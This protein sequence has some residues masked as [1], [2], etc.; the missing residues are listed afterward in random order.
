MNRARTNGFVHSHVSVTGI[1]NREDCTAMVA[2][3]FENVKSWYNTM[4]GLID[5]REQANYWLGLMPGELRELLDGGTWQEVSIGYSGVHVFRIHRHTSPHYYL[6]IAPQMLR[7]NLV[8]EK[9]RLHWLQTRLAVPKIYYYGSDAKYA[10]LLLSEIPGIMSCDPICEEDMPRL[11]RLLAEGLRM[12]HRIDIADCPFDQR[13]NRQLEAARQRLLAGLVDEADFDSE[14]S[15]RRASDVYE[16][17]IQARP[18]GEDLVFTHGDY[19]LP[20][21]ILD[22]DKAQI[23][24]FIDWER[25]GIADRYQDIALAARSLDYNF[26]Q[27][28]VPMLLEEYGLTAPDEEKMRFYRLLDEFF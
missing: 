6:K 4:R 20:N 18:A 3:M 23:S 28:W 17:L 22:W 12:I 25:G 16:Q 2:Q 19:C 13:L 15:G 5:M 10:Y 21:I 24:G 7:H 11:V 26:D 14:R 27:S 1:E 9:E 8:A